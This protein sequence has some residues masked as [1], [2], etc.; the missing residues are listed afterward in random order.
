MFK[1]VLLTFSLTAL[2]VIISVVGFV[3]WFGGLLDTPAQQVDATDTQWQQL[4]YL[5]N[6][7]PPRR[8]KILAV[9]TSTAEMG[10]SGKSTGYEL[11]ELARA[12]YVFVANGFEVD[13][14]SPLGGTPPVVIDDDD[15]GAYD[16]AFLNDPAAQAKVS[17]TIAVPDIDPQDY[18]AVY[19]VGG[20]GA[21][22]DFP[23]NDSIQALI[24][25]HYQANKV[26]GAV[27]HGPA[28]LV[29]VMLDSGEP[30]LANKK[31]SGFSNEEELFLISKAREIF[32]FLLEDRLAA[33]GARVEIGPIYLE[34]VSHDG[35]LVTGQNPWSVWLVAETMIKQLGYAP[36]ARPQ[37]TEERSV[38][39]LLTYENSGYQRAKAQVSALSL[40]EG[41][42]F[43][44]MLV[45]V[46]ALVAAMQWDLM[47]AFDLMSLVAS[48]DSQST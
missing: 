32:P 11:T 8:G 3:G 36:R 23:D 6:A 19:F 18:E 28:A 42:S 26:V 4:P 22:F 43:S 30:L 38:A 47:K 20:K 48:A 27:C 14:A 10:A 12:Y 15:M 33:Q 37:T 40:A 25:N 9:V 29:N 1:K 45:A 7:T 31:V 5:E 46:H 2:V 41:P 13:I 34:Q 39:I 21:M 16:F 24:K 17:A 35:N 44:Y